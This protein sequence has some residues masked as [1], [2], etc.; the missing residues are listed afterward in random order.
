MRAFACIGVLA[1]I[2]VIDSPRTV[3][4]TTPSS[5]EGTVDLP[6][7]HLV[8]TDTGGSGVPVVLLHA[9]T[10]SSRVWEYQRPAFVARGFR[11]IAY[12]RRGFG[13]STIDPSGPQPGT[14]ADDLRGLLDHLRLDRVHLVG[15]AAGG[16]VAWDF[17]LSFPD[18]LRSLVVASSIGGVQDPEYLDLQ[19]RLRPPEFAAMPPDIRE[20]GPSY[21]AANREGWERWKELEHTARPTVVPAAQRFLNTVTFARLETITVAT[22]LLTGDAD[23]FAPPSIMRMFA[24]RVKNSQAVVIPEAGHSAYWEN[25]EAFNKAVLAFLARH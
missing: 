20:L 14:G 1:S 3:A 15:T 9:A 5:R 18:R 12:D 16:F 11:V 22:L 6:G 25:P 2:V 24:A 23:M 8:Y 17:A 4:Q 19:R 21:R 10:G 13:S 7:V